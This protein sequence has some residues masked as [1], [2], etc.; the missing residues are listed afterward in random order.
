MLIIGLIRVHLELWLSVLWMKALLQYDIKILFIDVVEE[1]TIYEITPLK[2]NMCLLNGQT[3]QD[4]GNCTWMHALQGHTYMHTLAHTHT[5]ST[6][7]TSVESCDFWLSATVPLLDP[8]SWQEAC[9]SF[10][11]T[12]I[13]VTV[14]GE[15]RDTETL[16]ATHLDHHKTTVIRQQRWKWLNWSNC[17]DHK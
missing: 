17:T 13:C 16:Q 7:S 12:L 11:L 8:T 10:T 6:H 15:E 4:M 3:N 14:R 1:F 9:P 2:W 5:Y